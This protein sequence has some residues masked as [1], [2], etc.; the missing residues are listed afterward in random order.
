MTFFI[1]RCKC[2][3][4]LINKQHLPLNLGVTWQLIASAIELLKKNEVFTSF[5]FRHLPFLLR[6]VGGWTWRRWRTSVWLQKLS[7][8]SPWQVQSNLVITITTIRTLNLWTLLTGR[9]CS[10][11][12]LFY[13]KWKWDPI[14]VAV[15][16]K[17]LLAQVWLYLEIFRTKL[18]YIC[19]FY[20]MRKRP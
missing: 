20:N 11:A 7:D 1:N 15:V 6:L 5:R 16:G 8:R 10:E 4:C 3:L 14:R 13:K 12:A 2:L 17:G 18:V 19:T 9:R